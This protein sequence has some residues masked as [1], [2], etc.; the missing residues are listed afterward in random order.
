MKWLTN[1]K[2][3]I[4]LGGI[5]ALLLAVMAVMGWQGIYSVQT[6]SAWLAVVV[7][8][9]APQAMLIQEIDKDLYQVWSSLNGAAGGNKGNLGASKN[10][11]EENAEQIR[12]R[13]G[14]YRDILDKMPDK[15]DSDEF[16][17]YEQ[18]VRQYLDL[19]SGIMAA[20]EKRQKI[21]LSQV[22]EAYDRVQSMTDQLIADR[23]ERMES[24]FKESKLKTIAVE[25]DILLALVVSLL[26][27]LTFAFFLSRQIAR[28]LRVAIDL[29]ERM[30]NGNLSKTVSKPYRDEIGVIIAGLNKA[31]QNLRELIYGVVKASTEVY[32]ASSQMAQSSKQVSAATEQVAL[33]ISEIARGSNEQS[34]QAMQGAQMAS[35]ISEEVKEVMEK[36]QNGAQEAIRI[37]DL[38]GEGLKAINGQEKAVGQEGV[39]TREKTTRVLGLN[40]AAA[41][42]GTIVETVTGIAEQT[43]L[44]ALNAA[45]EA[46]RAGE[47]GRG[48]AVVANEVRKLAE[49]SADAARQIS[50]L[51]R[52]IQNDTVKNTTSAFEEISKA[53]RELVPLI[54]SIAEATE[55]LNSQAGSFMS[56]INNISA[57]TEETAAGAEE[58]SSA[59]EEQSASVQQIASHAEALVKMA[60]ILREKATIFNLQEITINCWD[61]MNCPPERSAMCPAYQ[62][63]EK[64]CWVISGTWCGGVQQGDAESKRHNCM[65]CRFFNK[66]LGLEGLKS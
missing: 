64:R 5:I 27:S 34:S 21:D 2:M 60:D 19:G 8:N 66:A 24:V 10:F 44:L 31:C 47:Q 14:F 57:V 39:D 52:V 9:E 30:A 37:R 26:V 41:E 4:K 45:I 3:M 28:E 38:V 65:N 25:R 13:L 6:L 62:S 49:Q 55:E 35:S 1:H 22:Q 43:N 48:F 50:D 7:D 33:T 63:S 40:Q 56:V 17:I 16:Q 36:T 46:A 15:E 18:A 59:A 61:V 42:I 11:F 32:V 54:H 53:T 51:V 23:K 20:A 58:V 29:A 12:I